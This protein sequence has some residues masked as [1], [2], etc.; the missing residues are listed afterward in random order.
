MTSAQT[1]RYIEVCGF[2]IPPGEKLYERV[3]VTELADGS[4]CSLPLIVI[5]G[6]REGP[7]LY[8]QACVHGDEVIGREI[9]TRVCQR[10]KPEELVGAIVGAPIV[11]VPAY[12]TKT[13]GFILEERGPIDMNRVF[14]GSENGLLT[15]RIAFRV[16]HDLLLK[17]DA[18]IDFH[19]GLA[20]AC[21]APFTYVTPAEGEEELLKKREALARVFGT[22][23]VYYH[24]RNE[25]WQRSNFT[26]SFAAQ[27]DQY[28]I[29]CIMAEAGEAG[30]LHPQFIEKNIQGVLNV[31]MHLGMITGTPLM[32][33]RQLRFDEYSVVRADRGGILHTHVKVGQKLNP[34]DLIAEI[35]DVHGIV[36]EQIRAPFECMMLRVMT[37]VVAYPGAEVAWIIDLSKARQL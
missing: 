14:P 2:K 37:A 5:N 13:R 11:N 22:D 25:R 19:S 16:F 35:A 3:P 24:H 30:K 29:P 26:Y 34:G 12:L 20:G 23:L 33:E 15:E 10:V 7:V 6:K 27:C 1:K 17:S 28:G 31:M 9:I 8:L 21:I 18:A 36:V 4:T 32:P